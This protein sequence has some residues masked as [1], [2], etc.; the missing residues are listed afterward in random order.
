[1]S[2][3]G[4]HNFQQSEFIECNR[5]HLLDLSV[6]VQHNIQQPEFIK[7]DHKNQSERQIN[8][9][10]QGKQIIVADNPAKKRVKKLFEESELTH[11]IDIYDKTSEYYRQWPNPQNSIRLEKGT[12]KKRKAFTVAELKQMEVIPATQLRGIGCTHT[13]SI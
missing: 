7:L 11:Y 1:L 6:F 10:A 3:I 9:I 12:A 8:L 2:A 4:Q 13:S 5:D